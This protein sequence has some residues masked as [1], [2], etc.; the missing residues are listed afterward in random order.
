[1]AHGK[2]RKLNRGGPCVQCG[3]TQSTLFRRSPE[4]T[5]CNPCG[6]RHKRQQQRQQ[7]ESIEVVGEGSSDQRSA[8]RCASEDTE[9]LLVEN[10]PVNASEPLISSEEHKVCSLCATDSSPL[11]RSVDGNLACNKCALRARRKGKRQ[12]DTPTEVRSRPLTIQSPFLCA[13]TRP[14]SAVGCVPASS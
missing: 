7:R 9:Q 14:T 13:F 4:G 10:K 2:S 6:L 12:S 1:M 5:M 3:A 11:W 8:E